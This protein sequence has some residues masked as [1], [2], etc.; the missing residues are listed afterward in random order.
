MGRARFGDNWGV[1]QA[2]SPAAG[3]VE[4]EEGVEES[5][6]T[7]PAMTLQAFGCTRRTIDA[8]WG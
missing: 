2:A 8:D 7:I 1:E 4:A 5:E 6:R 3:Q